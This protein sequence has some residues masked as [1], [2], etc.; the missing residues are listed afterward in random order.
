MLNNTQY[1][2]GDAVFISYIG[3]QLPDDY[4]DPGSTLV[5]ATTG[6]STACCNDGDINGSN[7]TNG[8]AGVV[9]EWLYP[10]GSSVPHGNESK[11]VDF[12]VFHYTNQIRLARAVADSEPPLGV[13]TCKVSEITT[14]IHHN[15]TI[16]VQLG[17]WT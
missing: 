6:V 15:A 12:A 7:K 3:L 1:L 11:I 9:G 8:R 2:P 10:N 14:G 13:Y 5:C 16:V 4:S 17:K